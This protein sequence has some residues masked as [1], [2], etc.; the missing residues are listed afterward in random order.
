LQRKTTYLHTRSYVNS[1]YGVYDRVN[2]LDKT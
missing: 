1:P 2:I